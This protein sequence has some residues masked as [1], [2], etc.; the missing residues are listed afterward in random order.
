MSAYTAPWTHYVAA[1]FFYLFGVSLFVFRASQGCLVFVGIL[2]MC[3]TLRRLDHKNIAAL[4]PLFC[5]LYPSF[6]MNERF[7]I[8]LTTFHIACLGIFLL[9]LVSQRIWLWLPAVFFGVT[10]HVLFLA[11]ALASLGVLAIEGRVLSRKNRI[12]IACAAIFLLPFFF[13]IE[14]TIPEKGKALVLIALAVAAAGIFGFSLHT[15]IPQSFRHKAFWLAVLVSLPFIVNQVFFGLGHWQL[16]LAKGESSFTWYEALYMLVFLG[17][18]TLCAKRMGK[19]YPSY[20]LFFC[21]CVALLGL[22][23]LKPA[24]RYFGMGILLQGVFILFA[25]W[26]WT[27]RWRWPA[28]SAFLLSGAL[29]LFQQYGLGASSVAQERA[30]HFLYFKDNS[31]DFMSKQE[32]AQFFGAKGCGVEEITSMDGRLLEALRFLSHGDWPVNSSQACGGKWRVERL[33][34]NVKPT[35]PPEQVIAGFGIWS[36]KKL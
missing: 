12:A 9:G 30:L 10:S 5:A 14:Q 3:L 21:L 8:E 29:L 7:A 23:M 32:L 2:C 4:L 19:E 6:V 22:M 17:A 13:H 27:G 20:S 26:Q 31:Q 33:G 25:L 24:P 28:L 15:K 11:P 35:I 34:F 36:E 1:G 18:V 16:L